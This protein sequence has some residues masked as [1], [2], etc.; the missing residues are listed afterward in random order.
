MEIAPVFLEGIHVRLEPLS[1]S[2]VTALTEIGIEPEIWRW[3]TNE[4]RDQADMQRYVDAALEAQRNGIAL[5]FATVDR[6]SNRVVGTT[7][8]GNIDRANR[9]AEIGWTWINPKWQ[10][11]AINTEAKLLM[12]RHAFEVWCCIR[13]EFKTDALNDQSRAALRRIGAK[14]E[15]MLRK[16]MI[17]DSGRIRDSVYYSVLDS[18]WPDVKAA[19]EKKLQR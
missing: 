18:E 8:F 1:S 4:V 10:R 13:V 19:L 6:T 5:P 3:M 15:G 17:A 9:R 11:S 7:R 16:H 2:H 12:L 14:E